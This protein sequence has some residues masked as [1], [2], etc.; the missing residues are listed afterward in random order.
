MQRIATV[1]DEQ[2]ERRHQLARGEDVRSV[3][4][5][6]P[7]RSVSAEETYNEDIDDPDILH[8]RVLRL[9]ARVWRRL[10]GSGL[11]GRTVTL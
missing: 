3:T 11:S 7:A 9:A 8:R 5:P 2:R 4:P 6:E 10:R 1:F